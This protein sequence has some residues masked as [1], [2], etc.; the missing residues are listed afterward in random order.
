[1]PAV[2]HKCSIPIL[3]AQPTQNW[4][5]SGIQIV[6]FAPDVCGRQKD[7]AGAALRI[8]VAKTGLL[9]FCCIGIVGQL[10]RDSAGKKD[11]ASDEAARRTAGMGTGEQRSG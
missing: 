7:H 2:V 5:G 4:T 6:V 11:G 9:A 3:V 1:M 10:I 8:N